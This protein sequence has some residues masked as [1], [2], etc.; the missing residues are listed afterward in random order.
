MTTISNFVANMQLNLNN[1]VISN[2]LTPNEITYINTLLQAELDISGNFGIISQ[3]KTEFNNI[4]KEGGISLHDIPDLILLITNILKTNILQNTIKNVGILN[5]IKFILD[6]L[7]DSNLLPLNT[8]ETALLKTLVDSSLQLLE[9]N[10][11]FVIKEEQCICN[12]FET[13]HFDFF[14]YI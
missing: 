6:T 5:I 12:I 3:I 4:I 2:N 8:N 7:F 13:C 11:D 14:K 10:I 1:P 9:T